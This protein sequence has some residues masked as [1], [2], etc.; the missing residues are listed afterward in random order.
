MHFPGSFKIH[1][2]LSINQYHL[3]I[4]PKIFFQLIL[5]SLLKYIEQKFNKLD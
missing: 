5:G 1:Y 2:I 4:T 3:K